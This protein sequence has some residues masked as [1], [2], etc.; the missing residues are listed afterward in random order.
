MIGSFNAGA[1]KNTLLKIAAMRRSF[2]GA[3][4]PKACNSGTKEGVANEVVTCRLRARMKQ[5]PGVGELASLPH[6]KADFIAP[7]DCAPVTNLPRR[8]G[9]GLRN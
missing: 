5:K 8:P 7:M 2:A 9:V 6:R 4:S 1:M 3:R